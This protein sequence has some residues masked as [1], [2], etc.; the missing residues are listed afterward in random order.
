MFS[1]R[2]SSVGNPSKERGWVFP[3]QLPDRMAKYKNS[4]GGVVVLMAVRIAH[5]GKKNAEVAQRG[6]KSTHT[7]CPE[8]NLR[9]KGVFCGRIRTILNK[10]S[11]EW[12]VKGRQSGQNGHAFCPF[13]STALWSNQDWYS[14]GSRHV[15]CSNMDI[16]RLVSKTSTNLQESRFHAFY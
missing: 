16:P 9:E 8:L 4:G 2:A 12:P 3:T 6:W 13:S 5:S 11:K 15:L 7:L 1:L 10:I 14:T